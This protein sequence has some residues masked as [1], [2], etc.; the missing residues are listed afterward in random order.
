MSFY[1]SRSVVLVSGTIRSLLSS[2]SAWAETA[3]TH[4]LPSIRLESIDGAVLEQLCQYWH[5]K[6]RWDGHTPPFPPFKLDVRQIEKILL[7]ASFLDT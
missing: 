1:V 5:Y 2:P 3:S 6:H 7:A 4:S